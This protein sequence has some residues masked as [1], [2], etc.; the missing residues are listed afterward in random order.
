MR[1]ERMLLSIVTALLL[2][3]VFVLAARTGAR[4]DEQPAAA[5][6]AG[7][8]DPPLRAPDFALLG[9]GGS[10]LSLKRYRGK[11]VLLTFGFT[12][13]AVVCPTTLATL[14]Q[15]R[16]SLGEASSSVQ[17]IFVTVDPE[18]DQAE[19]LRDYV[20]AF[21]PTFVGAT[22]TPEAL[23]AARRAYGVTA[24]REGNGRDDA[25]AHTS[26]IFL[27]DRGGKLR[28]MMPYGR[29]AAEYVND[30]RLLLQS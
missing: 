21:D 29:D 26:S 3:L 15:A 25:F 11:V 16:A 8:F 9:A 17:V 19:R 4:Q 7:A 13:C 6:K 10:R 14:A 28:A 2:G 18:R 12:S 5:M 20:T 1:K 27:I 22:G 23:T 30:V 24:T